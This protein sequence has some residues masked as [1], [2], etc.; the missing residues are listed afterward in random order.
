VINL[1]KFVLVVI[2]LVVGAGFT[3]INN[4]PVQ[5]D[6]YFV[7]PTLELSLVLWLAVGAGM[8]LGS[9]ASVS[10]FMRFKRENADLKRQSRLINQEVKNLRSMPINGH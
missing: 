1:I 6:L 4:T 8:L 5:I 7:A 2:F 9:L 3:V 10:Y